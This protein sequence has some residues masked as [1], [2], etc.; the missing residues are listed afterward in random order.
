MRKKYVLKI[1]III[2]LY[3]LKMKMKNI[4]YLHA[5]MKINTY[6]L[7]KIIIYAIGIVLKL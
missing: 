4:V 5:S 6:I 1:I 2:N 7:M 3:L